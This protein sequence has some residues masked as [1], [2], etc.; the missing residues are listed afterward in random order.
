MGR[1][2]S[3][4]QTNKQTQKKRLNETVL[5]STQNI[6]FELICKKINAV[7]RSKNLLNW[8]YALILY[9]GWHLI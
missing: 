4:K 6:M 9:S 8:P 1:K 3:N 2:E 5:L 7:L